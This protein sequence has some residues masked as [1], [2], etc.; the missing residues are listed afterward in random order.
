ML[1]Y[2]HNEDRRYTRIILLTPDAM[3]MEVRNFK[4]V[5][6]QSIQLLL[7]ISTQTVK[8]RSPSSITIDKYLAQKGNGNIPG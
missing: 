8:S 1:F 7:D 3:D 4:D 6:I 5:L 2:S